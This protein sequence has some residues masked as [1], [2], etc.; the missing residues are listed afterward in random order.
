MITGIF[1]FITLLINT[2]FLLVSGVLGIVFSFPI[3]FIVI[4][5]IVGLSGIAIV[6]GAIAF[7]RKCIL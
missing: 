7:I 3:W 2:I 1:T 4:I 6:A 5:N